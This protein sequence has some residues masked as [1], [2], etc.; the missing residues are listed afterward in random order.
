MPDEA[1]GSPHRETGPQPDADQSRQTRTTR[2]LG[3]LAGRS[4]GSLSKR[5][6]VAPL[7]RLGDRMLVAG[8]VASSNI[9]G[10]MPKK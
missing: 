5:G 1:A 6:Q 10:A 3:A 8:T 7:I 4:R 9:G 2:S